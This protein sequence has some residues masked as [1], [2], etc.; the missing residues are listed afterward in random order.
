MK[1]QKGVTLT[2]LAIYIVL[3]FIALAMIATVTANFQKNIKE[4]NEEGTEVS[5]ISNLNMYLLQEAKKQGNKISSLSAT[6]ITFTSGKIFRYSQEDGAIYLQD[7]NNSQVKI[8]I[9]SSIESCIFSKKIENEKEIIQVRIKL[10]NVE[11]KTMEYV[12]NSEELKNNT[13]N[14]E[15]YIYS[16]NTANNVNSN[17]INNEVNNVVNQV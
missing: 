8:Q 12:L 17:E 11:E 14:E 16:T 13:Q 3:V 5:E 10:E 2:T 1:S 15:M 7:T 4:S 9:A 6:Q